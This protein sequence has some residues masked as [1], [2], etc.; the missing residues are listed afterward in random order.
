MFIYTIFE[1]FIMLFLIKIRLYKFVFKIKETMKLKKIKK[2]EYK[3]K[4]NLKFK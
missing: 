4:K 3:K 1:L 2:L